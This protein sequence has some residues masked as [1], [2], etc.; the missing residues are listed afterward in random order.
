MLGYLPHMAAH[1]GGDAEQRPLQ[2]DLQDALRDMDRI[3]ER[4]PAIIIRG[5]WSPFREDELRERIDRC[6]LGIGRRFDP[7]E[8]EK[9][10]G[11]EGL[12]QPQ[13][14]RLRSRASRR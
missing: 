9:W 3:E 14:P 11:P 1:G 4:R 6:G 8:S 10:I 5:A 2:F 7:C 13:V 12:V